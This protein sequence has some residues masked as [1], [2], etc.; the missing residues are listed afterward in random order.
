[1]NVK[2]QLR[3]NENEL[4]DLAKRYEYQNQA[5]DKELTPL[6]PRIR[7]RGWMTKDE[8]R[9][10]AKWKAPRSAGHVEKNPDEYVKEIT[11][12][13][14][15]A[16]TERA[17]IEVLTTL[18]GVGWPMASV[19]LHFFHRDPYPI[20]DFRALWSVGLEDPW[21]YGFDFWWLYV[22]YC[23]GLANRTRLDMRSLDQAL[24]QYSKE[25]QPKAAATAGE[26]R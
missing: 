15:A 16:T 6:K 14:F 17:R 9:T 3:C 19:V 21:Q 24:W 23:R 12:F 4:A 13:A 8:L 2:A 11:E 22:A 10:V 25:N 1:M 5:E 20:L 18:D 26:S 7:Q